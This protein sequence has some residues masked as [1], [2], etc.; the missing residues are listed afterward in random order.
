MKKLFAQF[1]RFGVVG[2]L[3]FAVD[4]GFLAL[5]T[6]LLGISY[7]A[8]AT[9]SYVIGIVFNYQLSMRFVFTHREDM[10]LG[11]EFSLFFIGALIGLGINDVCMW[12]GVELL[13]IHY[14]VTKL[15]ATAIVAM[16][17]FITRKFFLDAE[18]LGG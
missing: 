6:E 17:N 12:V 14:L 10:S 4:Y 7:L 13:G 15:F 5:F 16:W 3:A 1:M 8:S 9:V 2:V 18:K 11:M